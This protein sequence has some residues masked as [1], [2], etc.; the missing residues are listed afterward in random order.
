MPK[1]NIC[2][3]GLSNQFV[4]KNALEL[5]KKLDMFYANASEIIQF[6]LF[7]ISRM[8]EMC[9]KDYLER[10]ETAVLKRI[11]TYENTIINIEYQLLNTETN[12]K[13]IKENCL[14]IYLKL[15]LSRFKKEL[16]EEHMSDS[17]KSLN[18]DLFKDRDFICSKKADIVVDCKDIEGEELLG[19]I[20]QKLLGYYE[21]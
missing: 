13:F 11:C 8:E 21:K 6:E 7:D 16:L 3:V 18:I 15:S 9:G 20:M 12:Y 2:L 10:K 17:A 19:L 5:S 1:A 4:D 14:I